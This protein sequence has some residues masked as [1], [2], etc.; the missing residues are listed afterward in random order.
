MMKYLLVSELSAL[1]VRKKSLTI[2]GEHRLCEIEAKV[3]THPTGMIAK[4]SSDTKKAMGV[5]WTHDKDL[6]VLYDDDDD[7]MSDEDAVSHDMFSY[8]D[9]GNR[10]ERANRHSIASV[11]STQTDSSS[12]TTTSYPI[13]S[14][15]VYLKRKNL[16][17]VSLHDYKSVVAYKGSTMLGLTDTENGTTITKLSHRA[18]DLGKETIPNEYRIEEITMWNGRIMLM[19][20]DHKLVVLDNDWEV[21]TIFGREVLAEIEIPGG[22]LGMED[23]CLLVSDCRREGSLHMYELIGEQLEKKWT[24]FGLVE[25]TKICTDR[26]GNIYTASASQSV[27]YVISPSG[28]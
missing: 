21:S 5:L 14:V 17:G 3:S 4:A 2:V 8:F 9:L 27:I 23:G 15:D 22:M 20:T 25:P 13:E 24:C 28:K 12:Q 7:E 19:T 18:I 26:Y 10:D 16:Q 6:V 11:N 1:I